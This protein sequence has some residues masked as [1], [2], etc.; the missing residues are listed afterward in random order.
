LVGSSSDLII[1]HDEAHRRVLVDHYGVR[2]PIEVVPHG[3][4]E[5][6][7][8]ASPERSSARCALAIDAE[9]EVLTFFGYF[10]GYKGLERLFC[11]LPKLLRERPKLH[12]VLAGDVPNRLAG[13]S[14][15]AKRA[16]LLAAADQRVHHLGFVP[17]HEVRNVLIASDVL[18]LPYTAG[19][20]ASG[21][22]ALAAA[23]G[24]PVLLSRLLANGVTGGFT[25]EP[26]PEGIEQVVNAFFENSAV[27]EQSRAFVLRLR[28]ERSWPAVA[29]RV[30]ALCNQT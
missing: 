17:E 30:F 6:P 27:R 1:V 23:C 15:L 10:A 11:A 8:P 26:T 5:T 2:R 19:I 3:V 13:S 9:Q 21:P 29:R 7:L 22:L 24:T 4:R 25:F 28:Q 16:A 12:V 14:P 18:I 20:S